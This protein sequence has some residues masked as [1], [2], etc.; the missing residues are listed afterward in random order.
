MPEELERS[1]ITFN[2]VAP[3]LHATELAHVVG[4]DDQSLAAGMATDLHVM[5]TA[6][7]SRALQFGPDLAARHRRFRVE[8]QHLSA[9]DEL[10]DSRQVVGAASRLLGAVV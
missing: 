6:R 2:G 5:R 10:R 7:H 1:I 8:R 4:D 9:R 3:G